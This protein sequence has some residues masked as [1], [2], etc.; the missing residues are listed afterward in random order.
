VSNLEAKVTPAIIAVDG[1]AACGK[2]TLSKTLAL[3]FKLRHLV[4]NELQADIIHGEN[5][6]VLASIPP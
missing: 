1:P 2:G 5:L 4:S 3:R 6:N